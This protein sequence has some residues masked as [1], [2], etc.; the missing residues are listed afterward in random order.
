M[1]VRT[2]YC[3]EASPSCLCSFH[4]FVLSRNFEINA[5][6]A[7]SRNHTIMCAT[8]RLRYFY[9]GHVRVLEFAAAYAN[10]EGNITAL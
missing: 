5:S 8:T 3:A 7:D 6:I 1:I 2:F 4:N 10:I 9:K